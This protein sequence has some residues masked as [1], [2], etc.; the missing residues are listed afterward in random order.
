MTFGSSIS[1]R[2]ESI[3][4]NGV[5]SL[6]LAA[7]ETN[8]ATNAVITILDGVSFVYSSLNVFVSVTSNSEP[9][10]CSLSLSSG[11]RNLIPIRSIY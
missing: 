3:S 7:T 2:V 1:V 11:V 8:D 6:T 4:V 10:Y 5:L 9:S